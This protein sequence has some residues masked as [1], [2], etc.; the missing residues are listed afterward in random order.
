MC[1]ALICIL[2]VSISASPFH[3]LSLESFNGCS[4]SYFDS[5]SDKFDNRD[6]IFSF[7]NSYQYNK[8]TA[9]S[10]TFSKL[11]SIAEEKNKGYAVVLGMELSI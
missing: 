6:R 1:S 10:L 7:S 3:N 2:A 5:K 9:I 4:I 11:N 8:Q